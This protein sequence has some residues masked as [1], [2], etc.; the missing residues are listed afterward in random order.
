VGLRR[1][2]TPDAEYKKPYDPDMPEWL[3]HGLDE[4]RALQPPL[5]EPIEVDRTR[6]RS[7]RLLSAILVV[8]LV[9]GLGFGFAGLWNDTPDPAESGRPQVTSL[10]RGPVRP[11]AGGEPVAAVAEALLPVV[12]QIETP[13]G[14]GS[15]VVYDADGFI[16]T[17]AHVVEGASDVTVRLADGDRVAGEVIG[18]DSATDVAVVRAAR[19]KLEVATLG[20]GVPVKVGQLAVAIGSP[21]GLEQT[22]TSGIVSAVDRAMVTQASAVTSMIQTDAPINPGNSGGALTDRQGRVIGINDAIRSDSGVNAGVGF[23]IPIDTAVSVADSLVRGMTPRIGFLGVSGT[24]PSSGRAGALVTQVSPDGPADEAGVQAGDLITTFDGEPVA[25]MIDLAAK[26]RQTQPGTVIGLS[27]V[28]NS[29]RMSIEVR[30]G[31]Q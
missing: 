23:A 22:V 26:V 11:G 15:G 5:D 21:F 19:R 6:S 8:A 13:S 24:E 20:V 29:N 18:A 25:S 14:L 30:I 27:V 28:R 7:I 17:A 9:A 4:R 3:R 12:V 1:R 10:P 2:R 16:L 31:E